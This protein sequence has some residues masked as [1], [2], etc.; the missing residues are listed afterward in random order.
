DC[1]GKHERKCEDRFS[2]HLQRGTTECQPIRNR[3]AHH[4]ENERCSKGKLQGKEERFKFKHHDQGLM[5]PKCS[6]MATACSP[7][8]KSTKPFAK[9]L[10]SPCRVITRP[11]SSGR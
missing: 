3:N 7:F 6:N 4:E 5:K 9:L 2:Q 11:C 10:P 1:R 8:T